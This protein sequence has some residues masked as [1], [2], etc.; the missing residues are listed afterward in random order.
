VISKRRYIVIG[1]IGRHMET[2]GFIRCGDP[3]KSPSDATVTLRLD[4][5]LRVLQVGR[6][7]VFNH[8]RAGRQRNES[9][10]R[11]AVGRSH[12]ELKA[13]A[14]KFGVLQHNGEFVGG[15]RKDPIG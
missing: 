10:G 14:S 12:G 11:L 4:A 5:F 7:G 3:S 1:G 13:A 9:P 15:F 8:P 2:Y 6:T